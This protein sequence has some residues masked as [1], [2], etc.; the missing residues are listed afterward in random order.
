MNSRT[1]AWITLI[2]IALV[3]GACASKPRVYTQTDPTADFSSYRTYG[4]YP[5]PAT[6]DADYESL[7]TNFLKVAVAQ[8]M[9][10]RGYR[11]DPKDPDLLVNFFVNTKEKVRSRSVPSMGMGMSGYYG[12]RDPFYDPWPGYAYETR[13]DQY[14]E[15]TLSVDV[16]DARARKLIWEGS[17]VGR[18]NDEVM[19]NMEREIDAGVAEVFAEFPVADPTASASR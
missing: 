18:I 11:Y 16:A 9:D 2:A 12:Y 13:I 14:T 10:R 15:G 8:Q 3:A 4:F 6:D 7:V 19:R 17:T 5:D 1:A